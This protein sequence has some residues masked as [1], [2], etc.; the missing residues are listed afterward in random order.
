MTTVEPIILLYA[1]RYAFGR[2]TSA[3][4]DALSAI[5]I[6]AASI[7][8]DAGVCQAIKSLL[9]EDWLP[10]WDEALGPL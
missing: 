5:V 7:R 1:A 8:R 4:R 10:D 3:P 9:S 2:Q 6:N